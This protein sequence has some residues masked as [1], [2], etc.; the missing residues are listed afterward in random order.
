MRGTS[1]NIQ[2]YKAYGIAM[3]DD[4]HINNITFLQANLCQYEKISRTRGRLINFQQVLTNRNARMEIEEGKTVTSGSLGELNSALVKNVVRL[5]AIKSCSA[6]ISRMRRICN[7][8]PLQIQNRSFKAEIFRQ[9]SAICCSGDHMQPML[10]Q[11]MA[12][13]PLISGFIILI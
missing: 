3:A 12:R 1:F 10:G 11:I 13:C 2:G 4:Y 9:D 8:E 6:S 7:L 5:R